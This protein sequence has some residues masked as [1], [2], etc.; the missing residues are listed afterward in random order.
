MPIDRKKTALVP[1]DPLFAS[2]KRWPAPLGHLE[3]FRTTAGYNLT[4]DH[5]R[6]ERIEDKYNELQQKL[7]EPE[8]AP[9]TSL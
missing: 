6:G 9:K 3:E 1:F 5:S 2:A 7:A 4:V 8:T